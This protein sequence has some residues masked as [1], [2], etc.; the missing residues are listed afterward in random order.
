MPKHYAT[1]LSRF[2]ACDDS[3]DVLSHDDC[4]GWYVSPTEY[5]HECICACHEPIVEGLS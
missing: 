2:Q 5:V 3:Q 1:R 4:L